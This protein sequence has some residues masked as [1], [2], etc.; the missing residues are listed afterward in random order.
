MLLFLMSYLNLSPKQK[1]TITALLYVLW[2][3]SFTTYSVIQE[4]K[5]LHQTLDRQL[6][7]AALLT[8]LLLPETHHH[9][10]MH[11]QNLTKEQDYKNTLSLSGFTDN[12]DVIYIY[13][14]ILRD[15]KVFFTSSSATE[16]ARQS[17]EDLSSNFE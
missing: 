11:K 13:T 16:E 12:S 7:D 1:I 8:R 14:L 3:F 4:K 10:G 2:L 6:E 15:N 5:E 9:Q 17:G